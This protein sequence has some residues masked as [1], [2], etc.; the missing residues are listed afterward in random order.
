MIAFQYKWYFDI[1]QLDVYRTVKSIIRSVTA[2]NM[3]TTINELF[4]HIKNIDVMKRKFDF[5]FG[6]IITIFFFLYY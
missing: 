4:A 6:I 1:F 5:I 3:N 2:D